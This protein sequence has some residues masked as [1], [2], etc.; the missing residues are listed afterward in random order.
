MYV[1]RG[2]VPVYGLL[3][4]MQGIRDELLLQ[5]IDEMVQYYGDDEAHLRDEFFCFRVL[6]GR[7][8]R[9]PE[10]EML[11]VERRIRM[12]DPLLEDDPWVKEKVAESRARGIA[13]GKV[14]SLR[15]V[16]VDIVTTR[17]PSL[18]PLAEAKTA[19]IE[20]PDILNVLV[21]QMSAASDEQAARRLLEGLSAS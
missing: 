3:P 11:R 2:A 17:F 18:I 5:A 16:L 6:L 15:S 20:Q 7:A 19:Q 14:E 4:T 12:F 8:Q 10:A 9:L 13:E 1:E 21:V